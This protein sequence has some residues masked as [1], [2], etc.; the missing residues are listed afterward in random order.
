MK[1]WRD[2]SA[3]SVK[4]FLKHYTDGDVGHG[5]N[6]YRCSKCGSEYPNVVDV[7]RCW[8]LY[9][10]QQVY[11]DGEYDREKHAIP[12]TFDENGEEIDG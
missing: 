10:G 8:Q 5:G 9:H 12:I 2:Y 4:D 11:D 7:R 6:R 1:S 3:V